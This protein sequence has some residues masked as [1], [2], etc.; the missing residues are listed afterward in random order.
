MF[1]TFF[2][3]FCF[4]H[5]KGQMLMNWLSTSFQ[6]I[7]N[8]LSDQELNMVTL[9]YC[10]NLMVAGVIKQIPDKMAPMQ[11]TFKVSIYVNF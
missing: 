5:T 10:T 9:Q 1:C 8:S 7:A 4:S 6:P 2:F 11:E 3:L